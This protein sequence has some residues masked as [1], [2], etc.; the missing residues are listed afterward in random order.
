VHARILQ[1]QQRTAAVEAEAERR[2]AAARRYKAEARQL[3]GDLAAAQAARSEAHGAAVAWM[4][5]CVGAAH[6]VP[7]GPCASRRGLTL[8][9]KLETPPRRMRCR[10]DFTSSLWER[11]G[12]LQTKSALVVIVNTASL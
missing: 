12:T 9:C 5:P 7:T 3:R 6:C 11:S 4:T 10:V 8:E 2:T 1:L